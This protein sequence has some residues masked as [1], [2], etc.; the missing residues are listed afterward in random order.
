M[1]ERQTKTCSCGARAEFAVTRT[2]DG[3][4]RTL[5]CGYH[6]ATTSRNVA[7]SVPAWATDPSTAVTVRELE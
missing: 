7:A 2:H 4:G 1:S 3:G 6:L 5:T